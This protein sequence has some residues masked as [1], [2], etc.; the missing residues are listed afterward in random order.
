M[1]ERARVRRRNGSWLGGSG[2]WGT[3]LAGL[4]LGWGRRVW[5]L[6]E[7]N[8]VGECCGCRL[9][10]A[11]NGS[12]S[13]THLGLATASSSSSTPVPGGPPPTSPHPTPPHPLTHAHRYAYSIASA[14]AEGGPI[15]YDLHVEWQ[16]Q[17]PW[18][19]KLTAQNGKPAYQIHFTCEQQGGGGGV[20][21][22][23]GVGGPVCGCVWGGGGGR[24][25][26]CR[27][28]CCCCCLPACR[29]HLTCERGQGLG[30]RRVG[31]GLRWL[32]QPS[33]CHRPEQQWQGE[34]G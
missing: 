10:A 22:G 5:A 13:H 19:D 26:R 4:G 16:L 34:G 32:L 8:H 1:G 20:R 14:T 25:C 21:V 12:A 9:R 24:A 33:W 2:G 15:R 7:V 28:C 3:R 29:R 23:V 30:V 27:C 18:D 31:Q 11:R 17:P 6:G